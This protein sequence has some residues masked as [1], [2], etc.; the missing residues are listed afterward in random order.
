MC[1]LTPFIHPRQKAQNRLCR[2]LRLILYQEVLRLRDGL[3]LD[4]VGD[5]RDRGTGEVT[6]PLLGCGREPNPT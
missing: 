3:P 4:L 5:L 6:E 2:R 1:G